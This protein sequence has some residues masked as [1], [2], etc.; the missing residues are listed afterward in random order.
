MLPF[1]KITNINPFP[2]PKTLIDP[3]LKQPGEKDMTIRLGRISLFFLAAFLI[4]NLLCIWRATQLRERLPDILTSQAEK[5][6][7]VRLTFQ[8]AKMVWTPLPALR[9][10]RLRLESMENTFSA[11]TAE[12][13]R[14]PFR[15]FPLL[16]DHVQFSGIHFR[17]GEGQWGRIPLQG[18]EGKV[19]GLGF[20]RSAS[21]EGKA[22]GADGKEIL[23]G[24]GKFSFENQGENFWKGLGLKGEIRVS[25]FS[26]TEGLSPEVLSRLSPP[27]Q[28]S[29]WNGLIR[30]NKEKT[31]EAVTGTAQFEARNL[32]VPNVPDFSLTGEGLLSWNL[33][34]GL[35]EFKQVLFK[36]PFGEIN[37]SGIWNAE[38]REIKEARFV[39]RKML[40]EN[41]LRAFPGLNRAL[42]LETGISGESEFDLTLRGS[43]DYLSFHASWNLT[44]AELTYRKIFSKPKDF[45]MNV[46][47]DLLLKEGSHLSG[48]LSARVGNATVK[49]AL[50]ELDVKSGQGEVTLLTNKFDLKNWVPL[51]RP[52]AP[53]TVSGEAKVLFSARGD[54]FHLRQVEKKMLNL[55]LDRVRFLRANGRGL[56]EGTAHIDWSP[57]NLRVK[58]A[59]FKL[60]GSSFQVQAEIFDFD[61]N[62]RG[63]FQVLSPRVE[64]EPFLQNLEELPVT[65]LFQ[66]ILPSWPRIE[67]E[68]RHFFP[69]GVPLEEFTLKGNVEPNKLTLEKMEFRALAGGFRIQ[70]ERDRSGGRSGF[71]L[72]IQLDQVSLARAF[73][74]MGRPDEG[75]EGNLF[76]TGQFAAEGGKGSLSVTNGEWHSLDLS[77]PIKNLN[78]FDAFLPGSSGTTPFHDLKAEWRFKGGRFETDELLLH[79]GDHWA[80][81]KGNLSLAGILNARLDVYLSEAWTEKLLH[82]WKSEETSEGRWLGPIPLLIVGNLT[83]PEVKADDRA[84]APFLESIRDRRF[85]RALRQP[86]RN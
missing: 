86:F 34:T 11:W 58:E 45:P 47:L 44:S 81:G 51:L 60:G 18:V 64:V 8:E 19:R 24:R 76:F 40:L 71:S 46:N 80:E 75:L 69:S 42:P 10:K 67:K 72:G 50:V 73:E 82:S 15:L 77:G 57:L 49:G 83:K 6:L 5:H 78:G 38:T 63:T 70:G 14:I 33:R 20:R 39:G 65:N 3:P 59:V 48:D 37:A 68:V 26:L 23:Q 12:E 53:A 25:S 32:S 36:S 52:V 7:R 79:T 41:A 22:K 43:W 54:L 4:G 61:K 85:R 30:L 55:T 35:F 28:K 9:L 62:P 1:L 21:F 13:A 74:A 66:K 31:N 29:Q 27:F 16:W 17:G 84:L 2:P 56:E